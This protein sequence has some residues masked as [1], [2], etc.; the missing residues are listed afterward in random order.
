MIDD[1]RSLQYISGSDPSD[2][3]VLSVEWLHMDDLKDTSHSYDQTIRIVLGIST[4]QV[5]CERFYLQIA[6]HGQFLYYFRMTSVRP[7]SFFF[8]YFA[9]EV[10]ESISSYYIKFVKLYMLCTIFRPNP[11]KFRLLN[12]ESWNRMNN[13]F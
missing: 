8:L 1:S 4:R 11:W 13:Y 3:R 7:L 2:V 12:F 5:W 9:W 6:R 10:N